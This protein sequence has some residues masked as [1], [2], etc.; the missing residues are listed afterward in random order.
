MKDFKN[1]VV[2]I[3]GGATGIG[4]SLA[5]QF[6]KEGAKV[7]MAGRRQNRVDQSVQQLRELGIEAGGTSC[8]VSDEE[9]VNNLLIF[10]IKVFGEVD[11][12]INNAGIV[13]TNDKPVIEISD[14]ELQKVLNINVRGTWNGVRIFGKYML[15]RGKECAIYNVGSENSFFKSVPH[16]GEYIASKHAL[17]GMTVA[18]RD[19]V[20]SYFKVGLIAPGLVQSEID[21][22]T[23]I[24]MATDKYTS[25]VMEQIKDEQFYIVS[26]AYNIEHI[27]KR[28]EE[29]SNA[30]KRY[31]PRYE[32]DDE[33]DIITLNNKMKK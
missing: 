3:T 19:E 16:G 26:H 18:L 24:G 11:I 21:E 10:S 6:G 7:I 30:Y 15:E 13:G 29:M 31:A 33:F 12:L 1:K 17:L 2:V 8:D 4:F 20:P 14:E 23:S 9:Q 5:K 27:T 28:Y 22:I 25:I 32:H